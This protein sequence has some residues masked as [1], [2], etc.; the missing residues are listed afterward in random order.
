MN[1]LWKLKCHQDEIGFMVDD[2][3]S[4][5]IAM[6][7]VVD[8][9][10]MERVLVLGVTTGQHDRAALQKAGADIVVSNLGEISSELINRRLA[11][12]Q[13]V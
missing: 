11:Q 9:Y 5:I 13:N 12:K 3:R 1:A 6:R 8:Y 4:G 10:G 2:A 7:A